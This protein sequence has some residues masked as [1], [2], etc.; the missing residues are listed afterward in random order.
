[1]AF[2]ILIGLA[3]RLE[4]SHSETP[5]IL[6]KH[7]LTTASKHREL[8]IK[9]E[10]ACVRQNQQEVREFIL[11]SIDEQFTSQDMAN[12][13]YLYKT[14]GLIPLDYKYKEELINLYT[15]Q[16]GGY[17][18][19]KRKR[20][21]MPTWVPDILQLPTAIH[22]LT[23][24]L[25]DQHF[26]LQNFYDPRNLSIDNSLARAALVEGD[27]TLLMLDSQRAIVG[28]ESLKFQSSVNSEIF[29]QSLNL[30]LVP[31][32]KA[33]PPSLTYSLLFPYT[34]GLRFVHQVIK[35]GGWSAINRAFSSPPES[36]EQILHPEKYL[37]NPKQDFRAIPDSEALNNSALEKAT[38]VDS[39]TL[40]EFVL[41]LMLASLLD[42]HDSIKAV[43]GWHGDKTIVFGN[44]NKKGVL[45][46]TEWDTDTH[47]QKFKTA[48][49]KYLALLK[50]KNTVNYEVK[51]PNAR[52]VV[53][54]VY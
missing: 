44:K 10:V 31:Q 51:T 3:T 35:Q 25:Q 9:Q 26:D 8:E 29:Q 50:S 5:C 22:E 12:E 17:Y 16:I 48:I 47:A 18:D 14:L 30:M 20:Y 24:A 45:V 34:S 15:S 33:A 11:Q 28:Q 49:V 46:Y 4:T 13:E 36:T 43:E 53:I 6:P 19:P 2:F 32:L 21:A 52:T 37:N 23:H 41:G 1:M 42:T 54:T 27:A 39:T 38:V 40:G 7:Y